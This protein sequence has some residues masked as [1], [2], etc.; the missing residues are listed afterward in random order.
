MN[1]WKF[2]TI[3][4]ELEEYFKTNSF[5]EGPKHGGA[6]PIPIKY[7]LRGVL[8]WLAGGS[9]HDIMYLCGSRKTSFITLRWKIIDA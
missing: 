5:H 8:R 2:D 7:L 3:L 1:D 9:Y 4:A 6:K